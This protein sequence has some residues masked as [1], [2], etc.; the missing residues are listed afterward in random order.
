M[1]RLD[2][3]TQQENSDEAII[4]DLLVNNISNYASGSKNI[5]ELRLNVLES[6]PFTIP[7]TTVLRRDI[8]AADTVITVDSTV[9][10]PRLNG[11]IEIDGEVITYR[12]KT[13]NQ[14][15]D[16]GKVLMALM[17]RHTLQMPM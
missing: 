10:F 16:C 12:T 3:Q 11:V 5:Y 1:L 6:Q 4:D 15:I 2:K 14:F 17:L 8:S 13:I 9:S 7:S